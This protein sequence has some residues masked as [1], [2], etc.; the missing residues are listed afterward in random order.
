MPYETNIEY[1]DTSKWILVDV[2]TG[3]FLSS[4][5]VLVEVTEMAMALDSEELSEY[6]N[7]H[8]H[9]LYAHV[10]PDAAL[11]GQAL[12]YPEDWGGPGL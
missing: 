3:E 1:L 8:G 6:A 2:E 9:A 11:G 10:K 4:N 5:A 12:E 7:A